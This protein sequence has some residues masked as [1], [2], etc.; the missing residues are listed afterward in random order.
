MNR[1]TAAAL[2]TTAVIGVTAG[3]VTAM[4]RG[5]DP[6][7]SAKGPGSSRS[8][9]P[10]S[11]GKPTGTVG[12][13]ATGQPATSDVL[14]ADGAFIHDG[15]K[16]VGLGGPLE[17]APDRLVRAKGGYLVAY[18][19][20]QNTDDDQ[21]LYFVSA[22]QGAVQVLSQRAR[23]WDL[24]PAGDRVVVH[25]LRNVAVIGFDGVTQETVGA[26]EGEQGVLWDGDTVTVHALQPDVGWRVWTWK[27][28]DAQLRLTD[29]VGFA[30]PRADRTGHQVFG[31]VTPDG[32]SG[33]EGNTCVGTGPNGT[34]ETGVNWFTCDWRLNSPWTAAVSPGGKRL[35]VVDSQTDGFGPG[36]FGVV[37][38]AKGPRAGVPTVDAPSEWMM[39]AAWL[40]DDTFAVVGSNTDEV[41]KAGGWIQ[42]CTTGGD[43]EQVVRT[44]TGKVTLGEQF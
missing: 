14:W 18:D 42:V 37:D 5:E 11:P 12:T 21:T 16:K 3:T 31:A 2:V 20:G 40:G 38:V 24:D 1:T 36:A 9:A 32:Y 15:E 22:P 8:N 35:L 17:G 33:A 41:G 6:T 25:D 23:S 30:D 27:P 43:C 13:G 34:G 7:G 28:G 29:R 39:D 19:N 26:P 44:R 4:V 10:S